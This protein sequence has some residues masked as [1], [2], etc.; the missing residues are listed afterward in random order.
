MHCKC[1]YEYTSISIDGTQCQSRRTNDTSLSSSSS[2]SN[3]SA[4]ESRFGAARFGALSALVEQTQ[5]VR[6]FVIG[7]L[8]A[9]LVQR[10]ELAR[11]TRVH[12]EQ[13]LQVTSHH[14]MILIQ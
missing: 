2:T 14:T 4:P 8:E 11:C 7:E 3:E 10:D 6:V 5:L 1:L 12:C 9:L 13:L